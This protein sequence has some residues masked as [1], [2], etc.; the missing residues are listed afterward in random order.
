MTAYFDAAAREIA[1]YASG[2]RD[3]DEAFLRAAGWLEKSV[4]DGVTRLTG[5][6]EFPDDLR[7]KILGDIAVWRI[8][9]RPGLPET[10][11]REAAR[12]FRRSD[13]VERLHL[14]FHELAL[15]GVSTRFGVLADDPLRSLLQR[16]QWED[17]RAVHFGADQ[18]ICGQKVHPDGSIKQ[19]ASLV[20]CWLCELA[21][22]ANR[23]RGN[24]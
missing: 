14:H 3:D 2:F 7:E 8:A 21:L 15:R 24:A 6:R 22:E 23:R 5:D 19:D 11:G 16:R 1:I 9:E 4:I 18:P 12:Q 10:R 13:L 17:E 20:T